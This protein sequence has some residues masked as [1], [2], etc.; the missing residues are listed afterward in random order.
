[1]GK[2]TEAEHSE[3]I[4]RLEER[5]KSK[6]TLVFREAEVRDVYTGKIVGEADLVGIVDG[7]F[8]VYE[9]KVN[10]RP[11]KARRQLLKIQSRLQN[12]G[13]VRLYYYTGTDN[14]IKE[15]K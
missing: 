10:D 3:L 6:Y 9:V 13:N 12:F 4:D 5:V 8:D 2:R 15:V 1:M 14:K 11:V 7:N